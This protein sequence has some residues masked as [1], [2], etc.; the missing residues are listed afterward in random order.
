MNGNKLITCLLLFVLLAPSVKSQNRIREIMKNPPAAFV[1]A[2][3]GDEHPD[4]KKVA[5][6]L[7]DHVGPHVET[8]SAAS[9]QF[10]GTIAGDLYLRSEHSEEYTKRL[11][12]EEGWYWHIDNAMWSPNG[13][14]IIAKQINDEGVPII[15]LTHGSPS[16]STFKTYSRAGEK[17]PIHQFYIIDTESWQLQAVEQ[18]ALILHH[19]IIASNSPANL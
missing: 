18:N 15:K 1:D 12:P 3:E 11:K 17:I 14:Y 9:K 10:A 4:A 7:F 6:G 13:K 8:Y 19:Q 2:M 16:D 5:P